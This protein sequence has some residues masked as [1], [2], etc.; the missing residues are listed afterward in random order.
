MCYV[1]VQ[2]A[3]HAH[4]YVTSLAYQR[5]CC[6]TENSVCICSR[7]R[8]VRIYFIRSV[9]FVDFLKKSSFKKIKINAAYTTYALKEAESKVLQCKVLLTYY[10]IGW[11][12]FIYFF[13]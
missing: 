3:S 7:W 12:I 13:T 8:D 10:N 4:A 9:V 2:C 6:S 1:I 11:L 5:V